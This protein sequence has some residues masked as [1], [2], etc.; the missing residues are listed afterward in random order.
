M[1]FNILLK[2]E[3]RIESYCPPGNDILRKK[4]DVLNIKEYDRDK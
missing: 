1:V 2:I 4:V 3:Q